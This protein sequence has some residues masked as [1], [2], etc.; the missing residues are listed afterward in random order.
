MSTWTMYFHQENTDRSATMVDKIEDPQH[1]PRVGDH[2]IIEGKTDLEFNVVMTVTDISYNF[3]Q[4]KIFVTQ[5]YV[6]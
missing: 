6:E 5:K 3:A 1:I 2:I 4:N